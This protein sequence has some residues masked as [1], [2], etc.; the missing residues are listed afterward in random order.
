LDPKILNQTNSTS[1]FSLKP[2]ILLMGVPR[3]WFS[4]HKGFAAPPSFFFCLLAVP[5]KSLKVI[6]TLFLPLF[7][8][9][10]REC[11]LD[12][13]LSAV[14]QRTY[15]SHTFMSFAGR[16]FRLWGSCG[17]PPL[18]HPWCY[19]FAVFYSFSQDGPCLT[20]VPLT[21]EL[22]DFCRILKTGCIPWHLPPSR[23]G[24]FSFPR[25]PNGPTKKTHQPP[26]FSPRIRPSIFR[27][28]QARP[29]QFTRDPSRFH[30]DFKFF[31]QFI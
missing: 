10:L 28:A 11:S 30:P 31:P 7:F 14:T 4:Q 6:P 24:S 22:I 27:R 12:G 9:S 25:A 17:P 26:N 2:S 15:S 21:P 23:S 20:P 13:S 1:P 5:P 29:H 19:S 3:H 8:L 16:S 18:H